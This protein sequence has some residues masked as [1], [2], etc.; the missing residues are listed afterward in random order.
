[1][2]VQSFDC[3]CSASYRGLTE[4]VGLNK[5]NTQEKIVPFTGFQSKSCQAVSPVSRQQR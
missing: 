5:N 4:R 3:L 2:I 1:M